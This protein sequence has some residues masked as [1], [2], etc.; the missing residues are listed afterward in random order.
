MTTKEAKRRGRPRLPKGNRLVDRLEARMALPADKRPPARAKPEPESFGAKM[1]QRIR[2]RR[3]QLR[4]SQAEL[5]KLTGLPQS[6][7]SLFEQ[8]Y[9]QDPGVQAIKNLALVLGV[10]TDWLI[11]MNL[12]DIDEE[13]SLGK[14]KPSVRAVFDVHA[15]KQAGLV[16]SG[17]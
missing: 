10:T 16:Q 3:Q 9:T 14:Y 6:M 13:L 1:G 15:D 12:V 2:R 8:G 11:G 5:S 4:L 17:T 7:I